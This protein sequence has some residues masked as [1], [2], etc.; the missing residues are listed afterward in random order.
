MNI[1]SEESSKISIS[2][3]GN[4]CIKGKNTAI[5]LFIGVVAISSLVLYKSAYPFQILL[6]SSSML[7]QTHSMGKLEDNL[8]EVLK[9]ASMEDKTV[10]LTTLND[11]WAEA[12][13]IFDLFLESFRIGNN[14]KG[15]L[16][17]LVIITLDEKAYGR[18]KEVHEHC[19]ALVSKG[20]N[21][22]DVAEFMTPNY[23]EMMWRRINFLSTILEMGYNFV[24]TD[25]DV[26]WLRN[27]FPHFY[28]DADFQIACD[29]YS[30]N[31]SDKNN[32][33]NGGFNYVKSNPR[34]IQF[35]QFWYSSRKLYPEMHDQDVLNMIKFDP[36]IDK[37]GL[38]MI[39]LD[40]NYF[41]GFCTPSEDFNLV[42]TMHANC[43]IGLENKIHDLK[44]VLQDWTKFLF[45]PPNLKA[46]PSSF[47]WRAPDNCRVHIEPSTGE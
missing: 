42:C 4:H 8:E 3:W 43:C 7:N 36:F 35:Y 5:F 9:A 24:F 1:S 2:C 12:G 31:S 22:T 19:Y 34:T 28:P 20:L 40:P 13:S 29:Y 47:S 17:H 10:I 37:L 26:M 18:C 11:A 44:L 30:G 38:K 45:S 32:A 41:G 6:P 46:L 15:L 33:P 23:L 21:F 25:A 16:S 39:F 14:T 27:P